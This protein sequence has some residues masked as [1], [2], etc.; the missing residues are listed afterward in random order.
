MNPG[1]DR[2]NR[3]GRPEAVPAQHKQN[4]IQTAVEGEE[5]LRAAKVSG[6]DTLRSSR[7]TEIDG[8]T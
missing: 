8:Y 4:L 2:R 5:R 3:E 1:Y 7:H 6:T